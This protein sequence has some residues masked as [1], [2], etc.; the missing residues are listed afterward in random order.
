MA[1]QVA[2]LS[3]RAWYCCRI[4]LICCWCC[5]CCWS[6]AELS[7]AA[8]CWARACAYCCLRGHST[9]YRTGRGLPGRRTPSAGL[10]EQVLVLELLQLVQVESGELL[11]PLQ[12]LLVTVPLSPTKDKQL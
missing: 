7:A 9:C 6:G 4:R 10:P 5:C 3:F 11:L 12:S 2:H 1:E 8:F